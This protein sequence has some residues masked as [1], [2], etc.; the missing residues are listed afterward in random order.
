M[1]GAAIWFA[2][3]ITELDTAPDLIFTCDMLNVADL[4]ALLP[5]KIRSLPIVTYFHENQ[6]TYPIPDEADRD[7]QYGFTNITTCLTSDEV[8]FNSEYHREAFLAA[9]D[10]LLKKMPDFVPPDVVG[11]IREKSRVMYPIVEEPPADIDRCS[12]PSGEPPVLLWSHRWEY[13]KNP[14]PFFNSL[15][16]LD[17]RGV[18]FRLVLLGETFRDAPAIFDEARAILEPRILHAG[19]APDRR[20]YWQWLCRSD[21]VVST[22][23]QE[24]FGISIVEAILAGCRPLLPNRLSYPELLPAERR[25]AYLYENDAGFADALSTAIQSWTLDRADERLV[26]ETLERFTLRG[27]GVDYDERF[28]HLA[29]GGDFDEKP[30]I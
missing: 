26:S 28:S 13:D 16:E 22:A 12:K 25:E 19:F 4:R 5:V 2:R 29:S 17:R 27:V 15:I 18:D 10:A 20:A 24:N 30:A 3:Q 14:E 8:W 9:V 23:I 21:I 7:F 11:M 6:L 1:R